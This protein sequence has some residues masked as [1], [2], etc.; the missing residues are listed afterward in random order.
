MKRLAE[1]RFE[2]IKLYGKLANISTEMSPEFLKDTSLIKELTG[3]D[4]ISPRKMHSQ[5]EI[6]F[7]QYAKQTHIG[8]K[9]PGT[10]KDDKA[11]YDRILLWIFPHEFAS[12]EDMDENILR[13]LTKPDELYG[14]VYI[15]I[16]SNITKIEECINPETHVLH[17]VNINILKNYFHGLS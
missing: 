11:F 8:N 10:Y 14:I 16:V 1:D 9:L 2:E 7:V 6:K 3:G 5:E 13:E 4:Q 15:V 17:E 12:G